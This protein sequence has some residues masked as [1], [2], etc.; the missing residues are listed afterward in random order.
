MHFDRSDLQQLTLEYI[1]KLSPER[2]ITLCDQLR[3]DLMTARDRLNQNPS[4]SSRPSSTL[5]PWDRQSKNK[6]FE[7]DED[8]QE[9]ADDP[10]SSSKSKT[11]DEQEEVEIL[12][13]SPK[14]SN[15]PQNLVE[16][17]NGDEAQKD[18]N[19]EKNGKDKKRKPGKQP[20]SQGFGR[21]QKLIVTKEIQLKPHCCKGCAKNFEVDAKF[22]ATGGYYSIDISPPEPGKIGLSGTYTKYIF[23]TIV[24]CC[25]YETASTPYRA[26][27][28]PN[29]TVEMGEWRLIG[30][31]LLAFIVFAKLRLHLTISKTKELLEC[32][33]GISL[34]KG[35]ISKALLEA[36][37]A[38][39]CLEPQIIAA[40]RTSGILH[41]DETSWKEH[42]V[43][44]WMWVAVGD[45]TV[46][47]CVGPRTLEMAQKIIGDFK[48]L[49][50]TDGYLAY[51]WY[52]NRGR[53]WSHLKRKG[54]ALEESCD[55]DANIFGGYVVQAFKSMQDSVYKMREM[56]SH[57][58]AKEASASDIIRIKLLMECLTNVDAKNEKVRAYAREVVND[59]QAIFRVLKEPDFPLTNNA[60]EQA[61]RPLVILRKISY[62]SKT[63]EGSRSIAM[64]A[65]AVETVRLRGYPIWSFFSSLFKARRSGCSPPPLPSSIFVPS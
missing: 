64:L 13:P 1:E 52:S 59:N 40:L 23:G 38:A 5:A 53:C 46:Y 39:S 32:W 47:F 49:L 21:T 10:D 56:Q 4:N 58:R 62:G 35:S 19:P 63:E 28:E 16:P 14:D 11:D 57:D 8:P 43:C 3:Q 50:M 41:V 15:D 44:R 51:R 61:L 31:M 24:C 25:G 34:S 45:Q 27:K 9:I 22:Q 12:T 18:G 6:D 33:F 26:D 17:Q 54:K 7:D 55:K 36:G 65:S 20:G 48:G 60:A 29:W 37:R 30:P 42:K 2:L